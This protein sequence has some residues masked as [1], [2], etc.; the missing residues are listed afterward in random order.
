MKNKE[1]EIKIRV[2]KKDFLTLQKI[3]QKKAKFIDEIHQQDHYFQPP[4]ENFINP[5]G[6]INKWFRLRVSSKE[7]FLTYKFVHSGEKVREKDE[8]ETKIEDPEAMKK[9][10][11]ALKFEEIVLVRKTRRIYMFRDIFELALDRIQELGYFIEI[12]IKK[13]FKSI[14]EGN[15]KIENIAKDLNLDIENESNLGYAH[16]M[17]IKKH[18]ASIPDFVTKKERR[19]LIASA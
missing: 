17:L 18:G 1:V 4:G 13:G 11:N 16:L 3:L 6:S 15:A 7:S 2:D 10:I 14:E 19:R 5:D 9:I 8:Y 12:E